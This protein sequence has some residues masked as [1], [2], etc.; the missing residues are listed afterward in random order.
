MPLMSTPILDA[1]QS[2]AGTTTEIS[3]S[4]LERTYFEWQKALEAAFQHG[5][6]ELLP[7]QASQTWDFLASRNVRALYVIRDAHKPYPSTQ[8]RSILPVTDNE[9][10]PSEA[11]IMSGTIPGRR[12][13]DSPAN[14]EIKEEPTNEIVIKEEPAD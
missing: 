10:Y 13:R 12:N 3:T 5:K 11:E 2:L 4:R 7:E 8:R 1:N 6:C 14:K 9:I